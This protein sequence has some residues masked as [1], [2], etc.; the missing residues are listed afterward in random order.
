MF[1]YMAIVGIDGIILAAN[2]ASVN[3]SGKEE[4]EFKGKAIWE[5]PWFNYSSSSIKQIKESIKQALNNKFVRFETMIYLKKQKMQYI[6]YSVKPITDKDGKIIFLI[7]EGRDITPLKHIECELQK[8]KNAAEIATISKNEFLASMS[9]EIRTPMNGIIAASDLA[10]QEIITPKLKNFMKIIHNSAYSLLEIIN[11]ILDVSK[12]EA[13]K[14][15]LEVR[16]FKLND[17]MHKVMDM[18]T[19]KAAEKRIELLFDIDFEAPNALMGDPVRLAQILINLCSNAVKFTGKDGKIIVKVES[20]KESS[21]QIILKFLVKD[22]GMGISPKYIDKLFEPFSQ[23]DGTTTRRH[24]GTGLGLSICKM[25]VEM[26]NGNIGVQS[27]QGKGS[28]FH[29]TVCLGIQPE[30]CQDKLISSQKIRRFNLSLA[31]DKMETTSIMKNSLASV[32]CRAAAD[33][34]FNNG[35]KI[36]EKYQDNK[37][38]VKLKAAILNFSTAL[39][40]ADPDKIEIF[41]EEFRTFLDNSTFN[42]LVNLVS[43][44]DYEDAKKLL[45]RLLRNANLS[46][47]C[48]GK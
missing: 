33:S 39:D 7:I 10:L 12:I 46:N 27:E 31:K 2:K 36:F 16:P 6:D 22:T 9:H 13:G 44:Y 48:V 45:D 29:F 41:L 24:G 43:C 28:L 20:W 30:G 37:D 19:T 21:D 47:F 26:M 32:D 14:L 5:S 17:L 34:S 11:D 25:L 42:Q 3:A 1:Q 35:L 18:F 4:S 15:K 40:L 23:E 38:S 8:A